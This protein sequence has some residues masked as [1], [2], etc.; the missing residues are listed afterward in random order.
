MTSG[1]D[2]KPVS[3]GDPRPVAPRAA[4]PHP[5]AAP[6]DLAERLI[7]RNGLK[8]LRICVGAVFLLFGALKYIPGA[9][10]IEGLVEQTWGA[11]TFGVVTGYAAMAITATMEVVVGVLFLAGVFMP[12]ALGLLAVTFVGIFSPLVLFPGELFPGGLPTLTAQYIVKDVVL[13]AAAIL[14]AGPVAGRLRD[15]VARGRR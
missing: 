6:L 11:L 7:A 13:V 10:P 4:N 12:V 5:L 1:T 15:R 3:L 9:S 2:T 14:V 8:A